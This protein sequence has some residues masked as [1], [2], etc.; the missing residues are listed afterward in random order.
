[1][2][3]EETR[4]ETGYRAPV[5]SDIETGFHSDFGAGPSEHVPAQILATGPVHPQAG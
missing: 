1:M 4:T 2:S 5:A 3:V